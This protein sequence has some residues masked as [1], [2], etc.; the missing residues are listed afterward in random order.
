MSADD[1][2]KWLHD[3][4]DKASRAELIKLID[5]MTRSAPGTI[6]AYR[7]LFKSLVDIK[8]TKE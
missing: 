2:R 5:G 6:Q 3:L 4:A 8:G 7:L 1:D